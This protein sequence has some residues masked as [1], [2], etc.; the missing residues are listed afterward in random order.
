MTTFNFDRDIPFE[1]NNPSDDQPLMKQNN[2]SIDDIIDVDHYSF[3]TQNLD[4]WHRQV[5]MPL[6]NVPSAQVDPASVIYTDNGTQSTTSCAKYR[7]ADGIFILNPIKAFGSFLLP[8]ANGAISLTTEMNIV[9]ANRDAA[10]QVT[11]VLDPAVVGTN[12]S[13]FLTQTSSVSFSQNIRWTAA[14]NTLILTSDSWTPTLT[15]IS[16]MILQN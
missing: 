2:N 13:V 7:S 9:S 14:A 6:N 1:D 15:F 10:S 8:I 4:G 16:F 12:W 5:T 3:E 11:I